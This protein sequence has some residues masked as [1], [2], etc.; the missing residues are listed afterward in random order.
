MAVY[1]IFPV[2]DT[3]IYSLNPSKNTGLDGILESTTNLSTT[4][5][6]TSRFL[7]QFSDTEINDIITNKISSSTWQ[8]N[9]KGYAAVLNG[10]N[11]TTT[12]EL[13]PLSGSWDMGTG[14]YNYIPENTDGASWRWRSYSGSNAWSTNGFSPFVTASY[15]GSRI[16][17]G[18]WYTGSA[19]ATVLPIYATQS[20][21]Y[22]DSG[23][24]DV[25][26]TNM[27]KAW[28][29]GS[30]VNNGFI[31]KQATEFINSKDYQIEM[32]FF[33]RDTHTIYPPQLEFRWRDYV[34]NTG[35]STTTILST[36]VATVSIDEN[37]GIFYPESINKF[38]VNSRPT[39]PARVFQT[40]SL[41]TTNYYLP[42]ASFF[43]VKDLDTNE[44]VIDFD[45]Q[46]TQ[47]SADDQSSY[48]TLYMNGLEP[49][50]YYKILIKSIINGST[51]IFDDNYYFK[52]ING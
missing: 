20:F 11:L 6:Q 41:Y 39:Y 8:A 51:I 49:E 27:V 52:V 24:I 44:F 29:S 14:R 46:Y 28:Y 47:L 12:L 43:A 5:P 45:D 42:T 50:R 30:I 16:G 10:L 37:P 26:I 3:S 17:G 7:V 15:S 1:K 31:V 22:F 23:D 35:S 33:S 9:F 19:N 25:N 36:Q 2:K 32:K 34:F 48:F 13:Y 4:G 21:E 18:T 38:R 40:A